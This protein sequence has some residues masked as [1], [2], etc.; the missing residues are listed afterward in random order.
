MLTAGLQVP[1][2]E[3]EEVVGKVNSVPELIDVGKLNV[4]VMLAFTVIVLVTVFAH[5]P[6]VGVKV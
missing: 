5:N 2:I 6:V 4:G 1:I 3:F